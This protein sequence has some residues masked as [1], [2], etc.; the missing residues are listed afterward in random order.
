M[1]NQG[2]TDVEIYGGTVNMWKS[3]MRCSFKLMV[4][5]VYIIYLIMKLL[6]KDKDRLF[7]SFSEFLSQI[8]GKWG[9]YIRYAFYKMALPK[10]GKD[11]CISFGTIF[12][13]PTVEL[14]N[15]VYIGLYCIIGN[16]SIGDN[17]LIASRVSIPSGKY[18]H[19]EK[20]EIFDRVNIGTNTW[21]GEGAVVLADLGTNCI[22]GAGSVVVDPIPNNSVAVGNPARVVKQKF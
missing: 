14:G 21:I 15:N 12:A 22:I 2:R 4:F 19:Y 6:V 17:V 11:C 13:H 18:Q 1:G 7:R 8:P 9:E 10:C 16:V 20:K 5:P 3:I